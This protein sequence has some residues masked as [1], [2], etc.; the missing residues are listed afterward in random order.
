MKR[1]LVG[2]VGL[3]VALVCFLAIGPTWVWA[4]KPIVLG[5]P[6]SLGFIEGKEGLAAVQMA[7]EEINSA[8]G[9]NVGGTKRPFEVVS[10]DTRGAEPG[11]PVAE[12]IKGYKKLIFE[13][14]VNFI[15][16]GAFRSEAAIAC[17]DLVSQHKVPM[18]LAIAMSPVVEEKI[19]SEY[20]KYKYTFRLCLNSVYL[21]KYLGG[22]MAYLNKE[23]GF[24]KAY[25]MVQDVAWARKTGEILAENVFKKTGWEIIGHEAYPTGAVD[26]A[27]GLTKAKE[28]K[29]EV[30][31]PI[32][33]MPT[34]G[35][36]VKQW[37]AMKIPA[38]L[39]GFISPLAGPS[40]WDAFDKQIAGALNCIYEIGNFPSQKWP[41]SVEFYEKYQKKYGKPIE[42]GHGPAPAYES[43]YVLKEAIE[44]AGTIEADKVVEA[45]EK[46]DREGVM[47]RIKFDKGHQVIFGD[48]PKEAAMGAMFQWREPGK[49][50]AVL[51]QSLAED[52][53]L[54]PEGLKPAK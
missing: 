28:G 36:L 1:S 46:T 48:D 45:L 49:R 30:I 38:V 52:K 3:V 47:G 54:L 5:V 27:S 18:L 14:K 44:R 6:T 9:V 15:V 7:V 11:V 40:A 21:V 42:S 32:F 24:N 34:S 31:V 25:I 53:I 22:T 41:K 50:V 20:D 26:F 39:A 35:V 17:M 4:E 12:V 16:V 37:K 10:L 29:A 2:L 51:P 13:N 23:F 8:G 19:K 43:V 33:D